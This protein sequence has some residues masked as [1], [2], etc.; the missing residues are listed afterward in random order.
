[1]G[2]LLCLFSIR[3][4]TFVRVAECFELHSLPLRGK[5]HFA[6]LIDHV[7]LSIHLS[8]NDRLHSNHIKHNLVEKESNDIAQL[9]GFLT[10]LIQNVVYN[11]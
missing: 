6:V 3:V 2:V 7:L 9:C 8:V 4:L 10:V 5:W 1:M 11:I